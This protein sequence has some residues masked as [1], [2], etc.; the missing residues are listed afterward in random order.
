DEG[1]GRTP[2][3]LTG[4]EEQGYALAF[5][6]EQ[7]LYFANYSQNLN[8]ATKTQ[9]IKVVQ[10]NEIYNFVKKNIFKIQ[11]VFEQNSKREKGDTFE[12]CINSKLLWILY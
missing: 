1:G 9:N 6:F 4:E 11:T 10:K 2:P 12:I 8:W 5:D 3:G 7:I